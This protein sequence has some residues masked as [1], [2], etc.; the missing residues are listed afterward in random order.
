[1]TEVINANADIGQ[2]ERLRA[3]ELG[4]CGP[5]PFTGDLS[6]S[7]VGRSIGSGR[8]CALASGDRGSDRPDREGG[9]AFGWSS[10]FTWAAAGITV[11]LMA[12]TPGLTGAARA[13]SNGGGGSRSGGSVF[14]VEQAGSASRPAR[15]NH[16]VAQ[17]IRVADATPASLQAGS[18]IRPRHGVGNTIHGIS[19][20]GGNRLNC[21][22]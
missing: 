12:G 8:P 21:R 15:A 3:I 20:N 1:V 22:D 18:A 4:I 10:T 7:A 13:A 9:D 19:V 2:P 16:R 17:R 6:A 5:E 14:N 11:G